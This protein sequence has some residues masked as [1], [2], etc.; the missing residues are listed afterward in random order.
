MKKQYL[1]KKLRRDVEFAHKVKGVIF[2][3]IKDV[4][5]EAGGFLEISPN[6]DG[7]FVLEKF[8]SN[9]VDV[10]HE[11][12]IGALRI[13]E[14]GELQYVLGRGEGFKPFWE[15]EDHWKSL[16]DEESRALLF[17]L[18]TLALAVADSF[19]TA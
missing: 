5:Q 4:V 11:L 1:Q 3:T 8:N 9:P 12:E 6:A 2:D 18:M 17:T 19:G 10:Y 14:D 16:E 7:A 15:D 13:N